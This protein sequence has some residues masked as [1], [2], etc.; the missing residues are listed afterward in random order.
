MTRFAALA[1][2]QPDRLG[3]SMPV[4]LRTLPF[5]GKVEVAGEFHDVLFG[6][7]AASIDLVVVDFDC[8]PYT[9]PR[10]ID[11]AHALPR[12]VRV[13]VIAK[14]RQQQRIAASSGADAI[15]LRGFTTSRLRSTIDSLLF[16]PQSQL[17]FN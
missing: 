14:N 5:V 10:L 2:L 13:L 15:L 12:N 6:M 1:I 8:V 7:Q 16:H 17:S 9:L 4:I 11:C 3:Q